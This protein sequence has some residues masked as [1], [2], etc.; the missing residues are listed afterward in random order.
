[1]PHVISNDLEVGFDLRITPS[2]IDEVKKMLDDWCKECDV[3]VNWATVS[4]K[5]L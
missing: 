4:T 3:T 2:E 5:I 1:M